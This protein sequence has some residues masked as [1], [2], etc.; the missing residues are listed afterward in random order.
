ME[1]SYRSINP[2]ETGYEPQNSKQFKP[3]ELV[4]N[5]YC[6]IDG[7]YCEQPQCDNCNYERM[8]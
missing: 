5:G 3:E 6:P 4:K 2:E 7:H 1:K 8:I